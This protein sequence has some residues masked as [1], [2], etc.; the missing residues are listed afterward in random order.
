M[1]R[2]ALAAVVLVVLAGASAC[3]PATPPPP[4]YLRPIVDSISTPEPTLPDG[5]ATIV[6]QAHDDQIISGISFRKLLV[7]D[8]RAFPTGIPCTST[9]DRND[10]QKSATFTVTCHVPAFANDGVWDLVANVADVAGTGYNYKGRDVHLPFQVTG[11]ADD[12]TAPHLESFTTDPAVITTATSNLTL[13][14]RFSDQAGAMPY[15][16]GAVWISKVGT[17]AGANPTIIC[18]FAEAQVV[19][20]TETDLLW[21][22]HVDTGRVQRGIQEGRLD[23]RDGLGH[24]GTPLVTGIEV[25]TA[26]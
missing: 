4:G 17:P 20:P 22:C 26:V 16:G 10:D 25:V 5:D 1:R 18:T 19:S 7:G 15:D 12:T 13:A 24:R 23:I 8:G 11:G 3:I 6:V 2:G 21:T 14:T 9:M